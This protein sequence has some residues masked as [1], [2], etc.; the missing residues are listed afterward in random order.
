MDLR[1]QFLSCSTM[2]SDIGTYIRYLHR[3]HKERIVYVSAEKLPDDG[4]RSSTMGFYVHSWKNHLTTH[5]VTLQVTIPA[6]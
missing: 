2:Y 3:D 5:L 6:V 4:F 1:Q